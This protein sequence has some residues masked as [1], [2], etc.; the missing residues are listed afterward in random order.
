MSPIIKEDE[1]K[2]VKSF[3]VKNVRYDINSWLED[4]LEESIKLAQTVDSSYTELWKIIRQTILNG[5]KRLR[6]FRMS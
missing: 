5:G 2:N 6:P 3:S 1:L 4:Y